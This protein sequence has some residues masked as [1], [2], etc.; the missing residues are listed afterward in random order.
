[1]N[2]QLNKI[3]GKHLKKTEEGKTYLHHK[4]YIWH[5]PHDLRQEIEVGDLV[6]VVGSQDYVKVIEIFQSEEPKNHQ[7][8]YRL[9][10]KSDS[11]DNFIYHLKR[12]QK[13]HQ[14]TQKQLAQSFG[15]SSGTLSAWLHKKS[16]PKK[17][18]YPKIEEI[19]GIKIKF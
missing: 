12:L 17:S 19:L 11:Q 6:E 13:E 10:R 3:K 8:I 4:T 9:V 7:M 15:V 18:L 1:M 2:K 5:I 14:F 16:K